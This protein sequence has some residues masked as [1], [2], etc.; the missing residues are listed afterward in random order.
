MLETVQIL[1]TLELHIIIDDVDG[2]VS[3]SVLE[4]FED[5]GVDFSEVGKL[6]RENRVTFLVIHV[7]V[8]LGRGV[9]E[10]LSLRQDFEASAW[11][12]LHIENI[13]ERFKFVWESRA[14]S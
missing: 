14:L 12:S 13:S 10:P 7:T 4:L 3:F 11:K 9:F 1:E 2:D 5:H 6:L 8:T